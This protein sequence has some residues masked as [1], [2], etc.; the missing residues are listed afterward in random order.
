M[1]KLEKINY[2]QTGF[3]L[4]E[5]MVVVAIIG[6]T[7]A[8]AMPS[9]KE[10]IQNT[11]IRATAESIQN[12]LQKAKTEALRHNARVNFTLNNDASWAVACA[13][14]VG[15]LDGDG[16]ADCPA[17]IESAP[18]ESSGDIDIN[19]DSGNMVVTFTNF[20]TRDATLAANEFAQITID[21]TSMDAADSRDLAVNVG[22]GGNIKMCDPNVT[23]PDPRAC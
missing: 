4:V 22:V 15:D 20:G 7:A 23:S 6:I 5:M 17:D 21:M 13:T 1:I 3:S 14:P 11:R 10:W 2:S 16:L 8:F 19:T 12:G 18:A 9:Y